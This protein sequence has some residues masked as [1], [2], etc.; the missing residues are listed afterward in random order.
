M[1][2]RACVEVVG[3]LRTPELVEIFG[4]GRGQRRAHFQPVRLH[5]VQRAQHAVEAAQDAQVVLRPV[6]LRPGQRLGVQRFID[7]A[8]EGQHGLFGIVRGE[9]GR[10]GFVARRVQTGQRVR[11]FHQTGDLL[12]RFGFECGDEFGG[13]ARKE[14]LGVSVEMRRCGVVQ[15]FGGRKKKEHK[16]GEPYGAIFT[17]RL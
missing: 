17:D 6:E 4:L 1:R 10:P 16:N 11:Q 15:G 13:L 9:G 12:G 7:I 3:N 5:P 14:R 8:V 2:G